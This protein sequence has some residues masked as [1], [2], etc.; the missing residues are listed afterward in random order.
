[1]KKLSLPTNFGQPLVE[2]M[3][4]GQ[5]HATLSGSLL[6]TFICARELAIGAK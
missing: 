5:G 3:G 4:Q 6:L 2:V 1:M